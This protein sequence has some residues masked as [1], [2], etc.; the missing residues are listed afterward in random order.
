MIKTEYYD[1]AQKYLD[2]PKRNAIDVLAEKG[3]WSCYVPAGIAFWGQKAGGWDNPNP[4]K[5][6]G[7]FLTSLCLGDQMRCLLVFVIAD[8]ESI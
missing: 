3:E 5:V 7:M 4:L 1:E 2:T 8:T 6:S